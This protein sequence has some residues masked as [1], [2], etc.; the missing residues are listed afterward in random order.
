MMAL[1]DQLPYPQH[2]IPEGSP[3]SH[4]LRQDGLDDDGVGVD[5][6]DVLVLASPVVIVN[7]KYSS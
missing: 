4:V 2:G 7:L 3:L 5:N 6:G 1:G